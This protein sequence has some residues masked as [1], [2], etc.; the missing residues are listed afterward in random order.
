MQCIKTWFSSS[1]P[2]TPKEEEYYNIAYKDAVTQHTN[3]N[4]LWPIISMF[5]YRGIQDFAFVHFDVKDFNAVNVVYN[6]GVANNLLC[7]IAKKN[8]KKKIE[9]F[10]QF[11]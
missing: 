6:H 2:S 7:R 9:H 11:L 3:W 1:V 5:G 8:G 10:I 4:Y